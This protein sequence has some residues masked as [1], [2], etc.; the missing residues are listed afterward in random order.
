MIKICVKCEE[1]KPLELFC[2]G[3]TYKDGRRGTCKK[4]HA[5]YQTQYYKDRPEKYAEKVRANSYYKANWKRH[6]ISEDKYSELLN[7]YEG[8]CHAC[9]DRAATNVDHDHSCC[10]KRFSCGE[11]VRGVLCS[12]CN[13]ALG[14]L[15]DDPEKVTRLLRYMSR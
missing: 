5:D 14:L 15:A 3:K 2:K 9:Q 4:C 13:T 10:P 11:C 8:K 6:K 7:L 12:Q 1:E